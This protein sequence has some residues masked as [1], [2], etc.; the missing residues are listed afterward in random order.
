MAR[1]HTCRS[2]ER[3]FLLT[4]KEKLAET[5]SGPAITNG[6]RISTYIAI[7]SHTSTPALV[8]RTVIAKFVVKYTNADL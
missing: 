4:G 5:A 8:S 7:V 3:N 2:F 1:S 6:S